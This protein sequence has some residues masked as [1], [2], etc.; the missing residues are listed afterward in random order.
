MSY[1][2]DDDNKL[3]FNNYP[4]KRIEVLAKETQSGNF[5]SYKCKVEI[6]KNIPGLITRLAE[7]SRP[8]ERP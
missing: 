1:I 8:T 6:L 7:D 5:K 3:Y 2:V 4:A